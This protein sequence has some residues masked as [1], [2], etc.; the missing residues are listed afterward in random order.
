[1]KTTPDILPIV[2]VLLGLSSA[3]LS[4]AEEPGEPAR[5]SSVEITPGCLT[6]VPE[7]GYDFRKMREALEAL[8][9]HGP[10]HERTTSIYLFALVCFLDGDFGAASKAAFDFQKH[11]KRSEPDRPAAKIGDRI[12]EV[13]EKGCLESAEDVKGVIY[14]YTSSRIPFPVDRGPKTRFFDTEKTIALFQLV[15]IMAK[16]EL[17]PAYGKAVAV[18]AEAAGGPKAADTG[19]ED[20][21]FEDAEELES[22]LPPGGKDEDAGGPELGPALGNERRTGE[23]PNAAEQARQRGLLL[24]RLLKTSL[25]RFSVCKKDEFLTAVCILAVHT[26]DLGETTPELRELI[27]HSVSALQLRQ[28]ALA[29]YLYLLDHDG[30]IPMPMRTLKQQNEVSTWCG[31]LFPY[32][33]LPRKLDHKNLRARVGLRWEL[34]PYESVFVYPADTRLRSALR[35]YAD[36]AGYEL[37]F[38]ADYHHQTV[39]A[40][41]AGKTV[42][43]KQ[44]KRTG[45]P[46]EKVNH[47]FLDGSVVL[48]LE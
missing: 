12:L 20:D 28:L 38:S 44:R 30:K 23:Q 2:V 37:L 43:L 1:M 19:E 31:F 26:I 42:L 40:L 11:L 8:R 4:K 41:D 15:E 17:S 48:K 34:L 47:L 13:M 18:L 36:Q 10:E 6:R 35:I 39:E 14:D 7:E 24:R 29:F 16:A 46:E 33:D 22:P 25:A 3:C 5:A 9:I 21:P 32:L 45:Q 27:T